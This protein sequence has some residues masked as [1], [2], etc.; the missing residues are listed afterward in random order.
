VTGVLD[1]PR[2]ITIDGRS[3]RFRNYDY[4][5]ERIEIQIEAMQRAEAE[6]ETDPD[7]ASAIWHHIAT[8]SAYLASLLAAQEQWLADYDLVMAQEIESLRAAIRNLPSSSYNGDEE[9]S[10]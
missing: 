4:L 3:E 2:D 7:G 1:Q 10:T 8:Q 6:L 9:G 5:V